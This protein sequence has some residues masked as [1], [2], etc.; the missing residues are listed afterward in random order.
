M[1]NLKVV[2]ALKTSY[3]EVEAAKENLFETEWQLEDAVESYARYLSE[4]CGAWMT[5]D[6]LAL[7]FDN[8]GIYTCRDAIR[9]AYYECQERLT[10]EA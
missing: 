2:E 10:E 8:D 4:S 9:D 6:E 5:R 1:N 3:E 7:I